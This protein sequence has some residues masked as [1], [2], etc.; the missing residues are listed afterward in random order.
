MS[1]APTPYRD[2]PGNSKLLNDWMDAYKGRF[3]DDP[4]LYSVIGYLLLDMFAKAAEKAGPNLTVDSFVK[5]LETNPY[6]R[7]F[8]GTPDYAFGPNLRLGNVQ[9]RINQIQNGRWQGVSDF[10]K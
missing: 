8:L 4:D 1:E 6:P 5:S 10:L 3:N 9:S 7:S 2:N